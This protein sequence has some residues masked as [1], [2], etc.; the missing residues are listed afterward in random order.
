MNIII[1]VVVIL[2]LIACFFYIK[3]TIKV[4]IRG[5]KTKIILILILV[6]IGILYL[7]MEFLYPRDF[8]A[9]GDIGGTISIAKLEK[10]NHYYI[11]FDKIKLECTKEQSDFLSNKTEC[12]IYYRLNFF[13]RKTGKI[14]KLDDKPIYYGNIQGASNIIAYQI[15]NRIN[16]YF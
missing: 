10:D 12:Y 9:K 4:N 13:N 5:N 1:L 8:Q 7:S 16:C 2:A 3:S 14:L 15:T 11:S 6:E